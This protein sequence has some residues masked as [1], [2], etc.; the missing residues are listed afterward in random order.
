[1]MIISVRSREIIRIDCTCFQI[2]DTDI[3]IFKEH[4]VCPLKKVRDLR[5]MLC[6]DILSIKYL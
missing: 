6:G 3:M 1:M 4:P 2:L 5:I